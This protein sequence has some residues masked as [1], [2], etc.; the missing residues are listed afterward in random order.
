[1]I[2]KIIM[3]IIFSMINH[4]MILDDHDD[5]LAAY[6]QKVKMS[7]DF[8]FPSKKSTEKSINSHEICLRQKSINHINSMIFHKKRTK[9]F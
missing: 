3:M 6:I 2:I 1:M 4:Q 9:V 8:A 7:A 5:D